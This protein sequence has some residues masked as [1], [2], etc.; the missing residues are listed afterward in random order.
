MWEKLEFINS[1]SSMVRWQTDGAYEARWARAR[2]VPPRR[3]T[4]RAHRLRIVQFH[5]RRCFR[6][7]SPTLCA[8]SLRQKEWFGSEHTSDAFVEKVSVVELEDAEVLSSLESLHCLPGDL[9]V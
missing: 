2:S 8:C 5:H 1:G 3:T 6:R 9:I 4:L 7:Y